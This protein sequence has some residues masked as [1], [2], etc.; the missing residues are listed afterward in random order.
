MSQ[1]VAHLDEMTQQNAALAEQSGRLRRLALGHGIGQLNDPRRRLQDR[2]GA[3]GAG[4]D[5]G[6]PA[7]TRRCL[8]PCR[9]ATAPLA[10]C[11][12]N[13]RSDLCTAAAAGHRQGRDDRRRRLG[14][15]SAC[16]SS[17][18]PPSPRP[19]RHPS[20]PPPR[21]SPMR[22]TTTRAG[23]SSEAT[24][25]FAQ[26]D[27]HSRKRALRRCAGPFSWQNRSS[28]GF[29][30]LCR[31]RITRQLSQAILLVH[32]T[33]L[34]SSADEALEDRAIIAGHRSTA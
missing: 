24:R 33:I 3:A 1:A 10:R 2:A 27:A 22:G 32:C 8:G 15:P 31:S 12:S 14:S 16:A 13:S 29:V 19:R 25:R 30:L 11:R 21:R 17:P 34:L 5:A 26:P 23:K 20:A 6:G 18:K 7:A 28:S 9:S 4:A